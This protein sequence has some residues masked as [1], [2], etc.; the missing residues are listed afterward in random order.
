MT[1]ALLIPTY[2]RWK[3][4]YSHRFQI[5]G[6]PIPDSKFQVCQ[7]SSWSYGPCSVSC[8]QGLQPA[9]RQKQNKIDT[10]QLFSDGFSWFF[11][12]FS[13]SS[14]PRWL[15]RGGGSCVCVCVCVFFWHVSTFLR[16]LQHGGGSCVGPTVATRQCNNHPCPPP[17]WSPSYVSSKMKLSPGWS[18]SNV[19]SKMKIFLACEWGPW[20]AWACSVTCGQVA[21]S[22]N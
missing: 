18:P 8:G 13:W 1:V 22:Y 11:H 4:T 16:W 3:H 7:W 19:L 20:S 21:T 6:L 12:C 10:F 2:F 14:F 17:G 9:T 5:P 15:Q